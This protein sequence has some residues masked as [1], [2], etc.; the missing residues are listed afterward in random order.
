M[1]LIHG[2]YTMV[3]VWGNVVM[4]DPHFASPHTLEDQTW[5]ACVALLSMPFIV[6][7]Y[8]G[9]WIK[10]DIYLRPFLYFFMANF[11]YELGCFFFPFMEEGMCAA[12]PGALKRGGGQAA[13][14]GFIRIFFF[15]ALLQVMGIVSYFI[16]IIW[17]C[18]ED[19]K[20]GQKNCLPEILGQPRHHREPG[21]QHA[22]F[23]GQNKGLEYGGF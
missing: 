22:L 9:L 7:G 12:I 15:V 2:I 17:S 8:Y 23:G 6:S 1:T 14:C 18:C 3:N 5:H 21:L 19:L 10:S 13:A 11:C 16:F 4:M 20:V